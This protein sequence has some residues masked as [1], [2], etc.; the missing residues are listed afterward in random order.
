MSIT[1]RCAGLQTAL[2]RPC[3]PQD[4]TRVTLTQGGAMTHKHFITGVLVAAFTI[5]GIQASGG[6]A[7]KS[8]LDQP[9]LAQ[10]HTP[11]DTAPKDTPP[12][13]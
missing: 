13:S 6:F 5:T 10:T 7:D 12:R 11:N 9:D 2:R 8:Q 4:G 1:D 3:V